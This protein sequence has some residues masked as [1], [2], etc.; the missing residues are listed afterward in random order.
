[1]HSSP[2]RI[3]VLLAVA[4]LFVTPV[5][6]GALVSPPPFAYHLRVVRVA[7]ESA[8]RG[9]ALGCGEKCGRPI[10]LPSEEAWGTPTQL[11]GLARALGGERADAVTGFIVVPESDGEARFDAT[12]YPGDVALALRF[13]ARALDEPDARHELRLELTASAS[14]PPLA[15]VH[16]LAATERTVAI[17][18]PSPVEGEWVVLAV[19]ALDPRAAQ[20]RAGKGAPIEH[21][22]G[23]VTPPEL[24]EKVS[25]EYPPQARAERREG[26]VMLQ[27]VI[28]V[29]GAVRA[30][31]VL[32]VPR[33]SEDFAAA[34][35]EAVQ[36]WR[37][38]PALAPDGHAV[39]VYFTIVVEFRLS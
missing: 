3:A 22:E 21:I 23:P 32:Q 15:E 16:L 17:A 33:G 34:A 35:V 36:A 28:D 26:R 11:A 39:P 9:A 25:P 10:V 27:A 38:R 2:Q 24:L 37:Y 6:L 14:E 29:E 8:G 5:G 31:T 20:E 30:I 4:V 1:M 13:S 18:A 12:I 7:G 19:T